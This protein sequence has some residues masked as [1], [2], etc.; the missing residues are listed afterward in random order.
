MKSQDI[1]LVDHEKSAGRNKYKQ[2][3]NVDDEVLVNLSNLVHSLENED[4]SKD[5]GPLL[6]FFHK[7]YI[8]QA[9]QSW[10]YYAQVNNHAKLTES[11][12]LLTRTLVVLRSN[13]NAL[14]YG[15]ILIKL[16]LD[17]YMKVLYRSLNNI[18]ASLT[19]PTIH[20][21][22]EMIDFNSG[23]YI[24]EF[25]SS[26]DFSLR[27]LPKILTVNKNDISSFN[28][29]NKNHRLH[30]R[31]EFIR[32]WL[33]LIS[34]CTPLL[35]RDLVIQNSKIMGAWFKQMDKA[36]TAELMEE[37][38]EV[39]CTKFVQEKA[40]KKMTKT[41]I[42]N[43]LA[44]SK[45]YSYFYS[46]NKSL[47][48]KVNEFFIA[49]GADPESSVA[50]PDNLPWYQESPF[51]TSLK[52]VPVTV[53]Q[54]DFRIHNKLLFNALKNFKPWES[55]MQAST[56]LKILDH[57]PELV[58]PYCHYLAS[59]GTHDPKM[60]S[61]WF[62]CT[63]LL[64][65][66]INLKIP[67]SMANIQSETAPSLDLVIQAIL[68][69]PLTKISLTKA[70]Q[71]EKMIIT[72]LAC[73][74][75]VFS[76]QK[77]SKVLKLYESKG[78]GSASAP[79]RNSFY[80]SIP[81]LTIITSVMNQSYLTAKNNK[82]MQ[83]SL[84]LLLKY[85]STTFPNFFSINMPSS[86][87]YM[88]IMRKDEFSGI[89]L[90]IVDNFL[91]FQELNGTQT[92]WWNAPAGQNSLFTS[93]LKMASSK[94]STNAVA[95]KISQLLQHMF[96][97]TVAFNEVLCSPLWILIYSLQVLSFEDHKNDEVNKIWK[98]LDETISRCMKM[99]Y[100][101]VD[102]S[103]DYEKISPFLVVLC[104]QWKFIDGQGSLESAA[105]WIC[106][107]L[108]TFI[109][110]GES[111]EGIRRLAESFVGVPKEYLDIY[112]TF[113]NYETK[114][115]KLCSDES[116]KLANFQGASFFQHITITPYS[117]LT[118]VVRYPVNELDAV[119]LI[120]RLQNLVRDRAITFN[121]M[122]KEVT[123]T[124]LAKLANFS[125]SNVSFRLI[126]P[127]VIKN[128]LP[129]SGY[130]D[131]EN[132]KSY[133]AS[134]ALFQLYHESNLN[135][136]AFEQFI[137]AWLK[138]HM[139]I[140]QSD[141]PNAMMFAS[142][143]CTCLQTIHAPTI[144]ENYKQINPQSLDII[145]QKVWE[146]PNQKVS[147][148]IFE[149][150]M[151]V[152]SSN[153]D[154]L[155][156]KFIA[157]DKIIDFQPENFVA[158]SLE[159]FPIAFETFARS[160]WFDFDLLLSYL[161]R[162]QGTEVALV[163]AL[164]L[165]ESNDSR[166]QE[167][168]QNVINDCCEKL[169]RQEISSGAL[170]LFCSRPEMLT[171]NQQLSA[172][173]HITTN[174]HEKYS[175]EVIKFVR[176][177]NNYDDPNVIA[178]LNKTILYGTKY[179]SNA[180]ELSPDFSLYL[181]ELEKLTASVNIW[182]KVN[183]TYLQAQHEVILT[184][185][186]VNNSRVLQYMIHLLMNGKGK[187]V[188]CTRMLQGILNNEK[189]ALKVENNDNF[190][191]FVTAAT[192][193]TLFMMDPQQNSTNIVQSKLIEL[194][195]GTMS[196]EDRMILKIIGEIETIT[197]SSWINESCS[198][199]LL[200]EENE[201]AGEYGSRKIV[202]LEREGTFITLD[203]NTILNTVN[204]FPLN[205]PIIP[206]QF[207]WEAL[208]SFYSDNTV[209]LSN[210]VG[211]I[212]DP[213]FLMLMSLQ[214]GAGLVTSSTAEDGSTTYK[215]EIQR[216]LMSDIFQIILLS[217]A[218]SGDL[219][220]ISLRII[221]GMLSSLEEDSQFKYG[222]IIAVLLKKIVFSFEKAKLE[223]KPFRIASCIWFAISR[224]SGLLVNPGSLLHETAFRWVLNSP[225]IM[226]NDFP[227]LQDLTTPNEKFRGYE[228]FYRQL[229][230][231]LECLDLGTKTDEDVHFM[232]QRSILE[233]LSNLKNLPYLNARL[234]TMI[235]SIF[236]KVQRL[237]DGG[238]TLLTR[239]ASASTLELQDL[240]LQQQLK[241]NASSIAKNKND[242][243][244]IRNKLVLETHRVNTSEILL[245]H[246]EI[247]N[248]QK[249][250]RLW[251]EDD[252]ENISKRI[253]N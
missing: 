105:K 245:G 107:L 14:E 238:S 169:D 8:S 244:L 184:G 48:K 31:F 168:L 83:L 132:M 228:N 216:Y 91:Q 170:K 231:V 212:Y 63:M 18:K 249:R 71:H 205:R 109:I 122:F 220:K 158:Q 232:K 226:P 101:Y 156:A 160:K 161:P 52:G 30:I 51:N 88:D 177:V 81:D 38:V 61:Y 142:A 147:F 193:F 25:T 92:K 150:A 183:H 235:D 16:I 53:N 174:Y 37:T 180:T 187:D 196:C 111:A 192:I 198:L 21:M 155:L 6:E 197:S 189:N 214:S 217:L 90:A 209:Y 131:N 11:T 27:S 97:G 75:L 28:P 60:T 229:A 162:I 66:I 236:Y 185:F 54:K 79:L 19:I 176:S 129:V 94:N 200:E 62:G 224:L 32:F 7:N 55:D 123:D 219:Q 178:W 157:E 240:F 99:P 191:R 13:A 137:F 106:I 227:L 159:K 143:I 93:L 139:D 208:F 250:V 70:L 72:Q 73:Q 141:E 127:E 74:L 153:L 78:W 116:F 179:F 23:Q 253:K 241:R 58:P 4:D 243:R 36:D 225:F 154:Q 82:V 68:P 24:E 223:D 57:V 215:F 239:F 152:P 134:Q 80:Q 100:R 45:I 172:V 59:H 213:E 43:E 149:Y 121:G 136:P 112:L 124:L 77:L 113:E 50:F 85:Y 76:F 140:L 130:L 89:D 167:F 251:A 102:S 42:L 173:R 218:E 242:K 117:K 10:S 49:Y 186:W 33:S 87:I 64:G 44:L 203:K 1:P 84:T 103:K 114:T 237:E 95:S 86:N 26:F 248:S 12:I 190:L 20:L 133:F 195:G 252:Q 2:S 234:Y 246:T 69:A 222:H 126:S 9:V 46:S 5:F 115:K 207:N 96:H 210:T 41:Q 39:L 165:P 125:N 247:M 166:L 221:Y 148:K 98:L 108:R 138:D 104:D 181:S 120:W 182:S 206:G 188:Q 171:K 34:H 201:T 110:C 128:L 146:I 145:L 15:G 230:W 17:N 3:G 135:N 35:R 175:S 202:A 163:A 29:T 119:G 151:K 56:V 204:N 40:F 22:K 233:W 144:L 65:R 164:S 47:V 194:Y 118:K 211:A 67:T 199:E